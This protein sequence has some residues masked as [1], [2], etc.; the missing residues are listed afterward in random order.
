MGVR[1]DRFMALEW[2]A[3]G[4]PGGI[5]VKSSTADSHQPFPN[6]AK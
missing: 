6:A 2:L 1:D 5:R 3:S 4:F